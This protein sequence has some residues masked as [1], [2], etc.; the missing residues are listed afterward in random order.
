MRIESGESMGLRTL[1]RA[2]DRMGTVMG[3]SMG[4]GAVLAPLIREGLSVVL[5]ALE[6]QAVVHVGQ[7]Y[8]LAPDVRIVFGSKEALR[9]RKRRTDSTHHKRDNNGVKQ[10]YK[11]GVNGVTSGFPPDPLSSSPILTVSDPNPELPP[12]DSSPEKLTGKARVR[13]PK[14]EKGAVFVPDEWVPTPS[15]QAFAGKHGL[16][17]ELEAI[18]FRGRFDGVPVV[19]VNGRFTTWLANQARW[20]K[21]RN[22][23]ANGTAKRDNG[24]TNWDAKLDAYE[25]DLERASKE[26][27]A[28]GT[29]SLPLWFS[30]K[31]RDTERMDRACMARVKAGDDS[32]PPGEVEHEA[33]RAPAHRVFDREPQQQP[34]ALGD[35]MAAAKLAQRAARRGSL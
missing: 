8:E 34:M 17:L 27:V 30:K 4:S 18:A 29:Q 6:R 32:A 24:V 3:R 13:A 12:S 25:A 2:A 22:G 23:T 16:D 21:E 26:R 15:H 1:V 33:R 35:V 20:S 10:G 11:D 5:P 7:E 28:S 14:K 9:Q 31:W 19:S